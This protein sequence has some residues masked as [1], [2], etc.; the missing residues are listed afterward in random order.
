MSEKRAQEF[1]LPKLILNLLGN[2][3]SEIF[4]IGNERFIGEKR[5]NSV[6]IELAIRNTLKMS[7]ENYRYVKQLLLRGTIRRRIKFEMKRGGD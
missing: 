6:L 7:L 2:R 1:F 3:K 4:V 5:E